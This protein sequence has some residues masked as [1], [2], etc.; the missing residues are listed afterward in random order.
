VRTRTRTLA[1]LS[2][3]VLLVTLTSV[4]PARAVVNDATTATVTVNAGS[5][6]ITVPGSKALGSVAT[7]SATVSAQLGTIAVTDQ[8]GRYLGAWAVTVS[9]GN[10]TTGGA[11]APE[12]ISKA[13]ADYWSGA[14]TSTTGIATFTPGQA[15]AG[16]KQALSTPRTAFSASSI[17]GNNSAAWN[18]TVIINIPSAAVAGG[19]S[20]TITHS[21]A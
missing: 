4:A 6:S 2:S 9:S 3:T 12:T 16:A 1:I 13:S 15:S 20:G 14:A 5:L 8:R 18:P 19:Y 17:I 10:Y 11:T 7:G 21:V